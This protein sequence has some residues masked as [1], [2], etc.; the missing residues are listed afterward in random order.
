MSAD[1]LKAPIPLPTEPLGRPPTATKSSSPDLFVRVDVTY[2]RQDFSQ[3]QPVEDA[4]PWPEMQRFD[5]L[6]RT[7]TVTEAE[8]ADY[9]EKLDKRE[10]GRPSSYHAAALVAAGADGEGRRAGGG[11]MAA[12]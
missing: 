3:L 12:G 7:R 5:F 8:A 10:P 11:G 4:N 2:L 1:A 9:R 6:V